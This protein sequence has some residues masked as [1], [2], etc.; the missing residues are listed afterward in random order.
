MVKIDEALLDASI[1]QMNWRYGVPV[2]ACK[3][4]YLVRKITV[5]NVRV[6]VH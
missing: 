6:S 5:T 1:L 3:S 2:N 4:N